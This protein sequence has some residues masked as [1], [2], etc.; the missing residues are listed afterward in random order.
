MVGNLRVLVKNMSVILVFINK[1]QDG[2]IH[3]QVRITSP[4][5]T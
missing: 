1:L 4:T 2:H 3:Y 5:K